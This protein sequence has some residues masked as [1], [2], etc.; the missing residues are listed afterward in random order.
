LPG[1]DYYVCGPAPFIK[2]QFQ[3]LTALG[4]DKDAIHYEEFGPNVLAL[5]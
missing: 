3:D 4:V 5:H 2:K 1:A